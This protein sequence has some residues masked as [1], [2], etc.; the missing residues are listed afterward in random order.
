VGVLVGA[1]IIVTAFAA[2]KL[3]TATL[4]FMLFCDV[5]ALGY[6]TKI[7]LF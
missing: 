4:V 2:A 1:V 6:L 3:V 7:A 5:V